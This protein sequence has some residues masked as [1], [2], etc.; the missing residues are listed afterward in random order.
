MNFT[1]LDYTVFF[2][3]VL[4]VIV[5]S[6]LGAR[7]RKADLSKISE[8]SIGGR[9]F[10]SVIVWFL[11]GGDIYT[12]YSLISIPGGA[13]SAGGLIL[14]ATVYGAISYPF[15]YFVAPRL[16]LIAKKHN[17]ITGADYVNARFDSR[18]LSLLVAL[19]GLL[20]MLPY[21]ALQ[22]V[23][24]KYVLEAMKF[25]V[26]TSFIIAFLIVAAFTI[27][28]GLRGPALGSV[29]KDVVLWGI[30][31]TVLVVLWMKFSGFGPVFSTLETSGKNVLIPDKLMLGF[32]TLAFGNGVAW[33]LFP[34]L[35]TGIFGSKSARIIKKNSILLPVYQIWL[36]FLA[37][38]G[39]VAL[40]ENLVP[41]GVSSLAFPSVLATYFPSTF[42]VIAFSGIIIGSMVPAS[43]QAL[44][45]ANLI[46]RNIYL[47]F[48]NKNAPESRQ[49]LIGRIFVV[50]MI[51]ASLL[52]AIVPAASG[53]IFYLLT[54]SYAWLLQTLPAIIISMYWKNLD[55][56]STGLGWAA[57]FAVVT[58]GLFDVHFSSSLL[59]TFG[60]MYVGIIGLAVNLAVLLV[61]RAIVASLNYRS[62]TKLQPG[63]YADFD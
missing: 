56:Y 2:L 17:F 26:L 59:P 23:G 30:I 29:I 31:L 42:V 63:D 33:L 8:W 27:V 16:Y 52:F 15:L 10:G 45:S 44:A 53:L 48:F 5:V 12:A 24:I 9:R 1:V 54:M 46:T 28:A 18:I 38:F 39:L 14:Y 21:I 32:I 25:P 13:F 35:L 36:M 41:S 40:A 43:L 51:F 4:A 34:N 19:T 61:A 47:E 55:K 11:M 3:I 7:W 62:T 20:A 58:W 50:V 6:F 49:V 57:G 37:I 60:Y 22:I